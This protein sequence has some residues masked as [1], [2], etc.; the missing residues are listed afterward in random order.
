LLN[1]TIFYYFV[2]DKMNKPL[3]IIGAGIAG[4]ASA[5]ALLDAGQ[6]VALF[7]KSR[8]PGGRMST[9]RGDGWQADHGAQ[10]F[11]ASDPSFQAELADWIDAG[12]AAVWQARLTVLGGNGRHVPD[13]TLSRYVGVPRMTAPCRWLARDMPLALQHTVIAINREAGGWRLHTA[14]HGELPTLY[15]GIVLAVPPAQAAPLLKEAAPALA[16]LAG[17]VR[18]RASWALMLQYPAPLALPFDAAFVNHGPLR[19]IARD[20]SKPGRDGSETWLLHAT[21]EWSEAHLE[22]APEAVA[23]M[24]IAAFRS[25]GAPPPSSWSAHRWRYADG[26]IEPPP[27]HA[28]DAGRRIALCGDWLNGGK[29]EGAWLSGRAAARALLATVG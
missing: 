17:A 3:A 5:R 2:Q 26:G 18:M 7:D 13:S 15:G 21:A 11:T 14:E 16:E 23:D 6:P 19:W 4:L 9:R 25:T 27:G 29:V 22:S 8:G 20:N 24:L 10:Y 12:V 1:I 28:C